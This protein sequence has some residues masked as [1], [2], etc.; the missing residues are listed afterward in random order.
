M[1][2]LPHLRELSIIAQPPHSILLDHLSIPPSA[3][4]R[5][6]FTF[7]GGESPVPSY[8]PRSPK[9]LHN[10]SHI[11]ALNLNLASGKRFARLNGPSG[12]LYIL[13]NWTQGI[14]EP[15]VGVSRFWRSLL[16][17]FDVSKN[18]RLAI[19]WCNY[20]PSASHRPSASARIETW[21]FYQTLH[22]MG[23]LRTLT[24]ARCNNLPFILTLNPN[25]N[26]SKIVLCPRLEEVILYVRVLGH[27]RINE[28]LGMAEERAS[29]GAKLSTISIVILGEEYVPKKE[30]FPLRKHVSRVE[31]RF[32]DTLPEWDT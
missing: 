31:Y 4:L 16:D 11:T 23:N 26:S 25:E 22:S 15:S 12:E 14:D 1:V 13:A 5:L 28:L 17:R 20:Q 10:L 2:S 24:L 30:V 29:R 8:L 19:T 7:S 3:S 21:A 9:N 32:D 18:Q 6:E 27:F